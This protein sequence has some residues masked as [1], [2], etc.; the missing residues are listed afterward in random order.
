MILDMPEGG[1]LSMSIESVTQAEVVAQM[2]ADPLL[3]RELRCTVLKQVSSQVQS[4]DVAAAGCGPAVGERSGKRPPVALDTKLTVNL[5]SMFPRSLT[6]PRSAC[7]LFGPRGTGK[8][9]WV[10]NTFPAA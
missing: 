9:T 6:V 4:I 5:V 10:R 3:P 7:F 2:S 8:S 1:G